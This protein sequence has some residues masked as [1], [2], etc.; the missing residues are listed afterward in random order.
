M[1]DAVTMVGAVRR[2][3]TS[4][5]LA[6]WEDNPKWGQGR[7]MCVATHPRRV[8][9]L[10]S[11][12]AAASPPTLDN[13]VDE[14]QVESRNRR[15]RDHGA[16][17]QAD[18]CQSPNNLGIRAIPTRS[19]DPQELLEVI[20]VAKFAVIRVGK[21]LTVDELTKKRTGVRW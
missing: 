7:G 6:D 16:G 3:H 14:R 13:C 19:H 8:S 2:A 9:S 11:A 5:F 21:A 17:S 18:Q 20:S 10:S 1:A 12:R 15:K 4:L